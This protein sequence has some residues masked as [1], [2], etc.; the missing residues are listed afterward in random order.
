MTD[1]HSPELIPSLNRPSGNWRYWRRVHLRWR[2][3]LNRWFQ[4]WK[5]DL[6]KR[7]SVFFDQ[8]AERDLTHRRELLETL[9][10]KLCN[11]TATLIQQV[12]QTADRIVLDQTVSRLIDR[13]IELTDDLRMHIR[14]SEAVEAFAPDP[15]LTEAGDIL[16]VTY[17]QLLE[18]LAILDVVPFESGKGR[19]DPTH[20]RP[21]SLIPTEDPDQDQ[22]V[23][24][25]IRPGFK[26]RH[27]VWRIELVTLYVL[28]KEKRN[29]KY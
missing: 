13:L 26:R 16:R 19:L 7:L 27:A 4:R 3:R 12:Q 6:D 11:T 17:G 1:P 29:E 14:C 28:E 21:V 2:Y 15:H 25:S 10:Q 9:D 5:D 18:V 22:Q 20:Q 24:E 23:C 8:S